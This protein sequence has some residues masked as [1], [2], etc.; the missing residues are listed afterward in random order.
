[1]QEIL[2]KLIFLHYF[3]AMSID[4]LIKFSDQK[5]TELVDE[6]EHNNNRG[7]VYC[8]ATCEREGKIGKASVN[9]KKGST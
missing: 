8:S 6:K 5:A 9:H 4:I 3:P 7:R 1:L 2:K